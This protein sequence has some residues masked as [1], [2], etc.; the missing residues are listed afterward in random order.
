MAALRIPR[1]AHIH[2]LAIVDD[3]SSDAQIPEWEVEA[4]GFEPLLINQ[5]F[6]SIEDLAAFIQMEA[7]G[8]LCAHRLA[9][10]GFSRFYGAKLV[11][12]LYDL[13]IPALLISR[14]AH[15]DNDVSIRKWRD[16][17][18]VLL[19]SDEA[20]AER[21]KRGIEQCLAELHGDVPESRRPYR[22]LL[23]ITDVAYESTEKV[24]DAILPG[25]NP[26]KAVRF[27]VSLLPP[28]LQEKVAPDV[29]FFARVN[30][31]TDNVDELYF[32]EFELAP[33][34]DDEDGLAS[35]DR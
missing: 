28:E 14:Y 13:K 19:H 20:D 3:E 30:I 7:Q 6:R 17:V 12:S 24:V 33:E 16:K 2:K 4:A 25:W 5:R 29:A 9:D 34:P 23:R 31:G 10:Y 11:A 8:V 32:R 22:V 26:R 21:I 27:P 35:T 1:Y 15:I 18:P